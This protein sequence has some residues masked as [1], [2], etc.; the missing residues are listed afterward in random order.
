MKLVK[1]KLSNL[2]VN[3][4]PKDTVNKDSTLMSTLKKIAI[5]KIMREINMHALVKTNDFLTQKR[6]ILCTIDQSN[7][8]S[9]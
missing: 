1:M 6:D 4:S 2:N 8:D 3:C 5:T 9:V 7:Y